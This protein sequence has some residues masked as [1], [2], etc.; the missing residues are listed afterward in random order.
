MEITARLVVQKT[1]TEIDLEFTILP[2]AVVVDRDIEERCSIF[3][4][5]MTK[6]VEVLEQAL[7]LK[8][9]KT[10]SDAL[11]V[12]LNTLMDKVE[13]AFSDIGTVGKKL[14]LMRNEAI[15][16]EKRK[17]N[18]VVRGLNEDDSLS[19]DQIASEL[20]E[21]IEVSP[22]F[23]KAER[24]GAKRS[25]GKPRPL[26]IRFKDLNVKELALRNATK[27]RKAIPEKVHFNINT[28]FICNDM[29]KLQRDADI[30]LRKKLEERR[31][32]DP[33]WVIKNGAIVKKHHGPPEDP[34][35]HC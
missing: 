22:E 6:R 8:T 17:Y 9:D 10:T 24:L 4:E 2:S 7:P 34:G 26:R 18:I 1:K 15:E 13:E 28:V 33:N 29:T 30:E 16:I 31:K 35:G 20:L 5:S 32:V 21:S 14:D 25:D 27:I 11:D 12:K 23:L 3:L 19:I